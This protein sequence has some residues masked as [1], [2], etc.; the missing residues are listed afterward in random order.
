MSTC[1]RTKPNCRLLVCRVTH[2]AGPGEYHLPALL[3]RSARVHTTTTA[4]RLRGAPPPPQSVPAA[5]RAAAGGGDVR[6][7][8]SGHTHVGSC[9]F[10]S[11][12]RFTP[13]ASSPGVGDYDLSHSSKAVVGGKLPGLEE[14]RQR[15]LRQPIDGASLKG[16]AI[17]RQARV[18]PWNTLQGGGGGG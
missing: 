8:T 10:G 14:P 15:K 3:A 5:A 16:G 6:V 2:Y 12:A 18:L 13:V 1:A 17:G 9:K 7:V 4:P 11:A